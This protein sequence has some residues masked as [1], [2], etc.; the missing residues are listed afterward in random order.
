MLINDRYNVYKLLQVTG[1][2]F[3]GLIALSA[4]V[5]LTAH[6]LEI[7]AVLFPSSLVGIFVAA[8]SIFLA[9]RINTGYSRWWLA[10]QVWGGLVNESRS[11]GMYVISMLRHGDR[12][13]DAEQERQ[14][15]IVFRHIG[16]INAVF[17][18]RC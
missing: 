18:C 5:G 2:K 17:S 7:Q 16:F 14:R 12:L 11:L 13:S 9:F 4:V 3:L 10:R 6:L 15:R 1:T 8:V